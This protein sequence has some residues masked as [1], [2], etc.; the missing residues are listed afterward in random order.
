MRGHVRR[1]LF[2][3][4][5]G[6]AG[7]AALMLLAG[8]CG[9]SSKKS[10]QP[11]PSTSGPSTTPAPTTTTTAP[12]PP[13]A[14]L[15]GLPQPDPAALRRVAVTVKIDNVD[16]ARPQAGLPAADIVF[17]EMVE[18]QLTRLI[19]IFQSTNADPVGPV[20]ST[21]TTDIDI[22]SALNRPLYAY[23]GGNTGFVNQLHAAPVVDVGAVAQGGAYFLGRR[24]A[25]H[26]TYTKTATL[27][28]LAPAG[29]GPPPAFFQ[30]RPTG[31][32]VA[33]TGAA[34]A[35][36]VDVSFGSAL[37]AWDWDPASSTWRRSQNGS[38]DVDQSGTQIA[39]ANVIVQFLSYTV[40]GYASGEGITPPP[41]IPKGQSVGQ[42][43]ADVFTGGML[44]KAKWSKASSTAVTSYTDTS[45]QPI[46]L[47]PGRTWVELAPVG[48]PTHTR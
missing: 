44:I 40:D 12:P 19:A 46:L 25:P 48:A 41:P 36:H 22:V 3:P 29:S 30:Y 13:V 1:R 38:A 11:L 28:G 21:R 15:T 33:G 32:A 7:L 16:P 27:F 4:E 39:P 31:Q 10:A 34:P 14:P 18:S 20:R 5:G 43:D 45:G 37:A 23:S 9:G 17:E 26:N 2:T 35:T 42:G 47:T 6:A 24:A 8:A